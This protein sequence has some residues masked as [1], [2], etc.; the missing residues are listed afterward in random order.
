MPCVCLHTEDCCLGL[1][2]QSGAAQSRRAA[3]V[4]K[5]VQEKVED[6]ALAIYIHHV[7]CNWNPRDNCALMAQGLVRS[8]HDFS[9][10]PAGGLLLADSNAYDGAA[11]ISLSVPTRFARLEVR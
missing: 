5:A 1:H 7:T 2:R 6:A 11:S 3:S 4:P 8:L 10:S 9:C